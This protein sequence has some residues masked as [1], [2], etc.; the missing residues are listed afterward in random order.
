MSRAAD[1]GNGKQNGFGGPY[2]T[3]SSTG[4]QISPGN[5]S[6]NASASLPASG[7]LP[8]WTV[9]SFSQTLG[10]TG[11]TA[12]AG[13]ALWDTLTFS[14]PGGTATLRFTVSGT[15]ND[16]GYP[17]SALG[18]ACLSVGSLDI[19]SCES[20]FGILNSASPSL[21]LTQ[22]IPLPAGTSSD[23]VGV[24]DATEVSGSFGIATADLFD[25]PFVSLTLPP[26]ESVSAA[27]GDPPGGPG[28]SSVPE[29]STLLLLGSGI[30]GLVAMRRFKK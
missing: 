8:A 4:L 9:Q 12:A 30:T 21:T 17:G 24:A 1:Y 23:M 6:A 26:G 5:G 10:I 18:G 28:P 19:A 22:T 11:A 25:P 27:S 2:L 16:G 14:G 15:F 29:P 13:S 20:S 7:G 3:A